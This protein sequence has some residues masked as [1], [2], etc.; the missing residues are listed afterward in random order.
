M[1]ATHIL[2]RRRHDQ[3]NELLE[4][5]KDYRA[6]CALVRVFVSNTEAK[7]AERSGPDY[8]AKLGHLKTLCA[9]LKSTP[10]EWGWTIDTT[11]GRRHVLVVELPTGQVA[12]HSPRRFAGPDYAKGIEEQTSRTIDRIGLYCQNL[13]CRIRKKNPDGDL[14]QDELHGCIAAVPN[15]KGQTNETARGNRIDGGVVRVCEAGSPRGDGSAGNGG[16]EDQGE[17]QPVDR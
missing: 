13:L 11:K 14:L 12:F 4:V 5:L 10:W 16:R 8:A 17:Q 2:G 6:T 9:E 7:L 15:S 3:I 1:N